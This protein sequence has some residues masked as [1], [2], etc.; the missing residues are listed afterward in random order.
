MP[1]QEPQVRRQLDEVTL[2]MDLI[3][4]EITMASA[5]NPIAGADKLAPTI[6]SSGTVP[7]RGPVPL[8]QALGP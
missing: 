1:R 5:A 2:V 7:L 4:T 3:S 6:H 8:A